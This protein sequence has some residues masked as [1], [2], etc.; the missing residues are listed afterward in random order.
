MAESGTSAGGRVARIRRCRQPAT[1]CDQAR[2][3]PAWLAVACAL[4]AACAPA[5]LA[6]STTYP[7]RAAWTAAVSG[8]QTVDFEAVA[9]HLVAGPSI[10]VSG[11]TFS[12]DPGAPGR[13]FIITAGLYAPTQTISSQGSG[14]GI[15]ALD[16]TLPAPAT[17]IAF[18]NF[19][20]S[21]TVMLPGGEQFAVTNGGAFFGITS[22][23]PIA[24]LRVVVPGGCGTLA[25]DDLAFGSSI[26]DTA[27][28]DTT[29]TA[30]PAAVTDDRT[31]TFEFSSSEPQSSFECRIDG[32]PWEPCSSPTTTAELTDGDQGE[33]AFDVRATD[34]AG[35]TDPTPATRSFVVQAP[36]RLRAEPAQAAIP[37]VLHLRI[38]PVATLTHAR[39]GAP[40]SGRRIVFSAGGSPV[41]SATTDAAGV[42]RCSGLLPLLGTLLG[43]GYDAR[44]AG[45][46]RFAAASTHGALIGLGQQ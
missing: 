31:P 3:L 27:A 20:C 32:G 29:I 10:V 35:N 6:A 24:S 42:A 15:E 1:R 17:A 38:S 4:S 11:V 2:R 25:I 9:P 46:P 18:D 30:G 28:P 45:E 26:T 34:L 40:V 23:E 44:F 21:A 41:C 39:T 12:L 43:A 16:I 5:A 37:D 22:T 13:L 8:I 19:I 7:D 36:T 14:R 33:H